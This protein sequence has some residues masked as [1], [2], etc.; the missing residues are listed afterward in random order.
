[1]SKISDYPAQVRKVKEE[2]LQLKI[3]V[4]LVPDGFHVTVLL[5]LMSPLHALCYPAK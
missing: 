5:T 3:K 1:L 4:S 2:Q